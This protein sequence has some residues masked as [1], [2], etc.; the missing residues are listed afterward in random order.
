[1]IIN[2]TNAIILQPLIFYYSKT[3]REAK[4]A[5]IVLPTIKAESRKIVEPGDWR[6]KLRIRRYS[7]AEEEVKKANAAIVEFDPIILLTAVSK[8]KPPSSMIEFLEQIDLR[9]KRVILGLVGAEETNPKAVDKLRRRVIERGPRF[10]TTIYLREVVT[11]P[12]WIDLG[13]ED[14]TREA[15]KLAELVFTVSEVP[16]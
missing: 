8:G 2:L 14:F 1:M 10:V 12:N 11:G 13:E 16:T 5:E 4:I 7:H 15:A 6:D 3:G 9:G